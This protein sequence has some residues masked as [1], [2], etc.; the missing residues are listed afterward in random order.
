MANNTGFKLIPGKPY[1]G[2]EGVSPFTTLLEYHHQRAAILSGL[3]MCEQMT[4]RQRIDINNNRRQW[5]E[6]WHWVLFQW[7][8]W[9]SD[10]VT[11]GQRDH[12]HSARSL[13]MAEQQRTGDMRPPSNPNSTNNIVRCDCEDVSFGGIEYAVE[14]GVD[15][16]H[17]DQVIC[18]S[19]GGQSRNRSEPFTRRKRY[20]HH[21]AIMT[22]E[23]SAQLSIDS[24][25]RRKVETAGEL[26]YEWY[27]MNNI[28][29]DPDK[30]FY[31]DLE[32]I[33][34]GERI[35]SPFSKPRDANGKRRK[36]GDFI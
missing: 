8:R 16:V 11:F 25:E 22:D 18:L 4:M 21:I 17:F 26:R 12:W 15:P 30:W 27:I 13:I 29:D 19:Q 23:N 3:D 10:Q 36:W 2:N 1:D 20:D 31:V 33:T 24:N 35:E 9:E 34:T 5:W 32:N 28:A 6:W 7:I 14:W